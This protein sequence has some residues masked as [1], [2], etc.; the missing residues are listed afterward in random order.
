VFAVRP[1]PSSRALLAVGDGVT[2]TS[3]TRR[4]TLRGGPSCCWPTTPR[5]MPMSGTPA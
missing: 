4:V 5:R 1:R 3:V 2:G